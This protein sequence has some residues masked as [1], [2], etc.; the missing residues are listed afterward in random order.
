MVSNKLIETIILVTFKEFGCGVCSV[1][2][3]SELGAGKAHAARSVL[4][5]SVVIGLVYGIVMAGLIYSLRDVWGWAFSNDFEVVQHVAHTAPY[6]A[7]LATLYAFGAIL[8][9][10]LTGPPCF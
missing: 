10:F 4:A 9:G 2:V 1:R 5:V 7:V 3:S 6:L 8:S